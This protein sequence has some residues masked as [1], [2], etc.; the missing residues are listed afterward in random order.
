MLV[1]AV[2]LVV[3]PAHAAT[4][5]Y[6]FA[7]LAGAPPSLAAV[8][9][10]Y[11]PYDVAVDAA[12]NIFIADAGNYV[13]RKLTPDGQM[14]VFA[15]EI[16]TRGTADGAGP[17]ARFKWVE[18]LIVDSTG[19]LYVGDVFAHTIRKISPAG[20][21]TTFAGQADTP[22]SADG[23]ASAARF[24]GPTGLALDRSGNL[25]V[26]DTNNHTI[27]KISPS[28]VVT[29]VAGRAG[30]EGTSDGTGSAARFDFPLGLAIDASG[31]I[32]IADGI[33]HAIR[34]MTP[35]GVVTTFAG[36]TA[37]KGTADGRGSAARF[38]LTRDV[39]IDASGIFYVVDQGNQTI[40]RITPAGDVTTF[41]G[42]PTVSGA[43]DGVGSAALF[44]DPWGIS[45]DLLG[46]VY[47]ADQGND[48][49]RKITP[50][51]LVTTLGTLATRQGS[52][53]GFGPNARF[54]S[55]QGV[56]V[57]RLGNVF[58][59]D[60]DNHTIRKITPGGD[61]STFAGQAGVSGDTDGQGSAARFNYPSDVAVDAM[62]NVFVADWLNHSIRKITPDGVVSTYAGT[63]FSGSNDGPGSQ[64]RF[65]FP[66]GIDVDALGN[67]YVADNG[68]ETIRMILPTREV[69]TIAGL[70]GSKGSTDGQGSSARFDSPSDVAVDSAGNVFVT[71]SF[72][73]TIRKITPSGVVTTFA[74]VADVDGTA[75]GNGSSARF[76]VP[77]NI[78]IDATGT[79]FVTDGHAIRQ[80]LPSGD[81]F[82]IAG[83]SRTSGYADGTGASALFSL[84]KGIA[85]DQTG[86]V[87]VA[88][89]SNH[90]IRYGFSAAAHPKRRAVRTH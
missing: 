76:N 58:V 83:Q 39:V 56:A 69:M 50:Q 31:N 23:T 81:V 36:N 20:E 10:L 6:S 27:R 44:N 9:P 61:V 57:D 21:V 13:I 77:E 70:A 86:R 62:G 34:R 29:T 54:N 17:A 2:F 59:A 5:D 7:S 32:F 18:Q 73:Y 63:G 79:M 75:D 90:S 30:T 40:R 38:Y 8:A 26:A 28:G 42:R 45:I 12:G 16:G 19:T 72:N 11:N 65:R 82:T 33:N 74:G 37:V 53:D 55:P 48:A 52:A 51:G 22:G 88:D 46:N 3:V 84:P 68:N 66:N 71:D 67:V 25:Y 49:I 35:S 15:G 47:V 4:H 85:V 78:T 89:S 24:D 41:A 80:I 43:T 87:Y 60:Q 1:V 64:A 14:T